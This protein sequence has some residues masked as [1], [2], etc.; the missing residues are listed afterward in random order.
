M[1]MPNYWIATLYA[2]IIVSS[3]HLPKEKI[4][5]RLIGHGLSD[6]FSLFISKLFLMSVDEN[7]NLYISVWLYTYSSFHQNNQSAANC[8]LVTV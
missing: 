5:I 4:I 8:S 7:T 1:R 3:K 6:L 2:L